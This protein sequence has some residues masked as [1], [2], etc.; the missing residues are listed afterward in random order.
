MHLVGRHLHLY[1]DARIYERQ[2]YLYLLK[3]KALTYLIVIGYTIHDVHKC[4]YIWN[5]YE[6]TNEC[7]NYKCENSRTVLL[8]AGVQTANNEHGLG[9]DTDRGICQYV[10]ELRT[11]TEDICIKLAS[12]DYVKIL[13]CLTYVM[14]RLLEVHPRYVH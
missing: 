3:L 13:I 11:A 12:N 8:R 1:Y 5:K 2:V 6:R 7:Q 4:V 14:L 9:E 10:K